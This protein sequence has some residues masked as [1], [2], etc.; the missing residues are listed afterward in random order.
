MK[1]LHCRFIPVILA[2][3]FSLAPG[4]RSIGQTVTL[5]SGS[6]IELRVILGR[7][8]D[9]QVGDPR[10]ST[11]WERSIDGINWLDWAGK[12][13]S[14]ILVDVTDSLYLRCAIRD[15]SCDP[16]YS[17]VLKLVP[18]G[19]P[20]VI[21]DPVSYITANSARGGGFVITDGNGDVTGRGLCW[22]ADAYPDTTSNKIAADS[23]TGPFYCV[24][25]GLS[26]DTE[27]YVVAYATNMAGT[28]YGNLISF[29]T[30]KINGIPDV[31]TCAITM[32]SET[33][34]SGGGIVTLDGGSPVTSR[35][36]CWSRNPDAGLTD[37]FV[38]AGKGI[39]PFNGRISGLDPDTRY[40]ARAFATNWTGTAYGP[41]IGFTTSGGTL[42]TGSFTDR[43]DGHTY[44]WVE[45]GGQVW[46]AG[47]LAYLPQVFAS[48]DGSDTDPRYY[49]QQY[50]G[51]SIPTAQWKDN[52][53]VYGVLYNW[54]AAMNGAHGSHQVPSGVRGI[55]PEGWHLPSDGE[56][57]NLMAYL[58]SQQGY[59]M[60]TVY[61]W[62][63]N[64]CGDNSSGFTGL[65]SGY[66]DYRG[67]FYDIGQ[68]G[69]F[70]TATDAISQTAYRYRLNYS[71]NGVWRDNWKQENGYS[72]R[73]I[74]D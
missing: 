29:K 49:V 13:G 54:P 55:C 74:K 24:I 57:S 11:Q 71:N 16:V 67:F 65:P 8:V 53:Q 19:L 17:D 45:I 50:E 43:R 6:F 3:C 35:G 32:I 68:Y 47:N 14:G 9:V 21:T 26:A 34:A 10:G 38:A 5:N 23:G 56:I 18:V 40:Y 69:N 51:Y 63:S 31:T 62:N 25:S 37:S 4:G 52:Y 28:A 46:M 33:D 7:S 60:K 58:A 42:E 72:I 27:Y 61:G 15:G 41:A 1:K 39:G 64:G 36:I 44:N 12:G 2:V 73:C 48:S 59:K 20:R 66:R 22:S 30:E 70:W